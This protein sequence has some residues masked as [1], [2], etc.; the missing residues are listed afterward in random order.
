MIVNADAKGL[1]VVCAAF[2]SQDPVLLKE[3]RDGVDIHGTNQKVF[4]L[5]EG[6]GGRLVAKVFKFR[7]LYGAMEY[8]FAKDPDFTHVSSSTK[9]WKQ[10]IDKYYNKYNVLAQ[11]HA[12]LIQE[13]TLTG[14]IVMPTGREYSYTLTERGDW[15]ITQIK[16]YP[17]QGFGA[18]VM[19]VVRVAF[20]KRFK[21]R[22]IDGFIVSSVHDS[23]V[24][25]VPEHSIPAVV[26]LFKEVFADVPRLLEQ[27]FGFK[28]DLTLNV[29]ISVVPNMS[30]LVEI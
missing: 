16:N 13:A 19:A 17:V 27:W 24:C 22:R 4:G 28:F 20:Y 9:F 15:P 26:A 18:D 3:L 21:D 2:L 12:K 8:S 11:W 29:E 5:G 30:D 10:V 1:E 23:I 25:D 14:K 7:L 6:K